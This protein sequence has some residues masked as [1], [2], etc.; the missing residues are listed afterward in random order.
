[1]KWWPWCHGYRSVHPD[2]QETEPAYIN[3]IW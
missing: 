2:R 1:M 3:E